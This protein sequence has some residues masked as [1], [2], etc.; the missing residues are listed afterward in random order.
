MSRIGEILAWT[1]NRLFPALKMHRELLLA[2]SSVAANQKWAYDEA[3]RIYPYFGAYWDLAGKLVLD[4]GTGLG[5]KLPFYIESGAR[6]VCGVDIEMQAVDIAQRYVDSLGL[7]RSV[8]LVAADAA[9]LPFRSNIFD[10][11]IS[12]NTFEHITRVE[13]ALHECHRVLKPGG[14]ALLFLPPYYSPWGPHLE[15]WIHFPWPHLLFSE[16]TLM[17]VAARE[18]AQ[19]RLSQRF[20]DI[21]PSQWVWDASRIPNVN[22]LTLKRFLGIVSKTGFSIK[23]ITL[24]PVGYEF[25]RSRSLI[26]QALL[27]ILRVMTS[28]PFLQEVVVTKIACVLQKTA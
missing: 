9:T 22:Y 17:R 24:L 8:L 25:L 6:T 3:L 14:I 2:K 18:D 28:L 5:G 12:I 19:L 1:L 26:K 4:L 21:S 15:L 13:Q 7:S 23:Q 11:I 10:V 16:K 20:V 27:S